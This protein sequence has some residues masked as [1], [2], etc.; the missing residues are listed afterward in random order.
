MPV[1]KAAQSIDYWGIA[2][3]IFGNVV[4][5]NSEIV[6]DHRVCSAC[7]V[8][9]VFV[10]AFNTPCSKGKKASSK[11]AVLAA[12]YGNEQRKVYADTQAGPAMLKDSGER[13]TFST[14]AKRD[15]Q[16]GKGM[17]SLVPNFV[18]WLVSRV[19]E[20]GAIKYA[21]RNWEKGMPLSQYIDSAERHLAK[22][23][24]GMRDEPH[25]SQVI[26][27]MMGYVFT[28]ALIKLGLREG[29]LNDMPNQLHCVLEM[30]AEPL[31]PHEYE[32]LSSF[33]GK[34]LD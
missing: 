22:L 26:W 34:K 21:K 4:K 28:A 20:D 8:S 11:P 2:Q 5:S 30:I 31:S 16:H 19:Y 24:C 3:H 9:D 29:S 12:P 7:G 33:F 1:A 18:I 23:K 15:R 32:S 17:P 14:G 6:P 25:A 27:N 10:N 13:T